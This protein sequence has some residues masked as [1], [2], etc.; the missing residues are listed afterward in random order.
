MHGFSSVR[1]LMASRGLWR[2]TSCS[3]FQAMLPGITPS[4]TAARKA[5]VVGEDKRA[6]SFPSEGVGGWGV[7]RSNVV[8]TM[9]VNWFYRERKVQ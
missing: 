8:H 1:P 7:R 6:S 3:Q 9:M 5:R 2:S 4:S